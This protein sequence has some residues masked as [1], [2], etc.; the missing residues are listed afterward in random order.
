MHINQA[1]LHGKLEH[2]NSNKTDAQHCVLHWVMDSSRD[3]HEI[4]IF[5]RAV[6]ILRYAQHRGSRVRQLHVSQKE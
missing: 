2:I 4:E 1:N 6:K 5:R 3:K